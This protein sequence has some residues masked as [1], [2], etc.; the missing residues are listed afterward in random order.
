MAWSFYF[1]QLAPEPV[2]G[3]ERVRQVVK[4]IEVVW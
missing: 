4:A 1:K 2:V 3:M